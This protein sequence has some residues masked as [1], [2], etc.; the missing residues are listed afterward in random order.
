MAETGK[1]PSPDIVAAQQEGEEALK[2]IFDAGAFTIT[3]ISTSPEG[4]NVANR[5]SRRRR[6]V[7]SKYPLTDGESDIL[8]RRMKGEI[9]FAQET[10]QKV[11]QSQARE[12][13]N[14]DYV[15]AMRPLVGIRNIEQYGNNI[16]F[17]VK[18]VTYAVYSDLML[19]ENA[20]DEL[21]SFA[22][23]SG[24]AA[25]IFTSDGKLLIQYRGKGN[26]AYKNIPGAS[27]AG[28][29]RGQFDRRL[30]VKGTLDSVDSK[31][32]TR[33]L[34]GEIREELQV[35]ED[36]V[37]TKT[38][39]IAHDEVKPHH[40]FLITAFI[41]KTADELEER[42]LIPDDQEGHD[43][44]E[45]FFAIEGSPQAVEKLLTEVHCPLPPTHSAVFFLATYLRILQTG[46]EKVANQWAIR[47]I[48]RIKKN[49]EYMDE[50][51]KQHYS[52]F[53]SKTGNLPVRSKIGYD[54][55]YTPEQQGLPPLLDELKR[56]GLISEPLYEKLKT[57]YL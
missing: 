5:I 44:K 29:L 22:E 1:T 45:R 6:E 18:P 51:V 10:A 47:V 49:Y 19:K 57:K 27:A 11:A 41:D 4:F 35:D 43:F 46:D 37:I 13:T 48:D 8:R 7:G 30:L 52:E 39:G 36:Q 53:P 33:N 2:P 17:D 26:R 21:L 31:F 24:T 3:N 56:T 12:T 42:G 38:I 40:E 20:R 14:R 55:M 28:L 32:V 23:G 54:P 16:F 50:I 9:E 34:K 15:N 25:A